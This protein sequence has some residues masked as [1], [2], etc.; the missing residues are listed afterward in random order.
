MT[1]TA[2]PKPQPKVNLTPEDVPFED[3]IRKLLAA[4][5]PHDPRPSKAQ[6][7]RK[8]GTKK[9]GPRS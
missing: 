8:Q 2:K 3:V 5:P 9:K 4:P 6:P 1:V 7:K